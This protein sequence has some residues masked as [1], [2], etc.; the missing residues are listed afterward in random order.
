MVSTDYDTQSPI[1]YSDSGLHL[2]MQ[3]KRQSQNID[4]N[5][6]ESKRY[7]RIKFQSLDVGSTKHVANINGISCSNGHFKDESSQLFFLRNGFTE[8]YACPDL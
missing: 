8:T 6:E 1:S 2:F 5:S 3:M 7:F 4:F